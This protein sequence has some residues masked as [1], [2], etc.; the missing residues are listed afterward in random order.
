VIVFLKDAEFP[1]YC[2]KCGQPATTT[3]R[4]QL[5]WHPTWVTLTVLLNLLLYVIIA[6]V[7]RK[8]ATVQVPVCAAHAERRRKIIRIGWGSALLGLLLPFVL[9]GLD[10]AREPLALGL[11][12]S[13]ILLLMVPLVAAIMARLLVPT[14]IDDRLAR[15][16]GAHPDFL[17]NLMPSPWPWG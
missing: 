4:Q 10:V 14:F 8:T 5:S 16:K 6:S 7:V 15:V 12:V 17:R 11:C 3:I 13:L 2:V 9:M 1:H